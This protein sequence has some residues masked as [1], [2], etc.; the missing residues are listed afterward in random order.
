MTVPQIGFYHLT[1][2]RLEESLPKLLEKGLKANYRFLVLLPSQEKLKS[3]DEWLWSYEAT[4]WLPHG[5]STE[6]QADQ[7]PI[8]LSLEAK[9]I[10]QA[11]CLVLTEGLDCE[12]L[13]EYSRCFIFFDGTDPDRLNKARQQWSKWSKLGYHLVYYQQ[14]DAGGWSEVTSTQADS[15]S[16]IPKKSGE[17]EQ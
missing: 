7:Q 16:K 4:S 8:L 11:N 12:S 1:Q 10:N 5:C 14:N 15:T 9:A 13:S 6:E 3:L 2:S 17:T